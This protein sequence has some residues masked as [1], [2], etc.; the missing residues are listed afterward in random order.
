MHPVQD[1]LSFLAIGKCNVLHI[2]V[3]MLQHIFTFILDPGSCLDQ[4]TPM[5]YEKL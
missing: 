3:F 1:K 5:K 4:L 2:F